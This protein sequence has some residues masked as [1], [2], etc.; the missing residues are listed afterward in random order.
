MLNYRKLANNNISETKKDNIDIQQIV[1]EDTIMDNK[2]DNL[3]N[4]KNDINLQKGGDNIYN[5]VSNT[6]NSNIIVETDFET[7]TFTFY[8]N[9]KNLLGSFSVYE[10]IKFITVNVSNNFL[11]AINSSTAKPII[12]KYIC[13]VALSD[14][15]NKY[16]IN[17][18][19]WLESSFMGNI[20]TLTKLYLL[21]N[22]F[23]RNELTNE[24]SKLNEQE[25]KNVITIHN[26]M[27]YNLINHIL[28]VISLLNG[29]LV[30]NSVTRETLLKY[31]ISLV[32]RLS[33]YIKN[34]LDIKVHNIEKLKINLQDIN[35]QEQNIND[36]LTKLENMMSINN[37]DNKHTGN[38]D[39]LVTSDYP[40]QQ[41]VNNTDTDRSMIYD[42]RTGKKQKSDNDLSDLV[43]TV[44]KIRSLNSDRGKVNNKIPSIIDMV[45]MNNN[46]KSSDNFY[47]SENNSNGG[48]INYLSSN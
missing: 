32:H 21:I 15:T 19:N 14:D 30:Q 4:T 6:Q 17:M 33:R 34:E 18:L 46:I 7:K 47:Y 37:K 13:N 20:D 25:R 38:T 5:V 31:S 8:D 43:S 40:I 45:S 3:L 35:I 2:T 36:R 28:K 23:E 24:L 48:N 11:I 44:D 10:F 12:E 9:N 22:N 41:S 1:N 29:K 27:I 26:T 42:T 16:T 39:M